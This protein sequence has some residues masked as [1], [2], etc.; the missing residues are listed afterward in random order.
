MT[1][2]CSCCCGACCNGTSC[3]LTTA[4]DCVGTGSV[5]FKGVGTTCSPNPCGPGA[6]CYG[7]NNC[8]CIDGTA[9]YC[10]SIGGTFKGAGTSCET[11]CRS[12]SCPSVVYPVYVYRTGGLPVPG[13]CTPTLAGI[14]PAPG[15]AVTVSGGVPTGGSTYSSVEAQALDACG[16]CVYSQNTFRNDGQAA[17]L[18]VNFFF[19]GAPF[20]G[21]Y[22]WCNNNMCANPLP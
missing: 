4:D 10:Q 9:A 22:P 3:T 6:C 2:T 16:R 18:F 5:S 17:V 8:F 15:G 12:C 19:V 14:V 13:N 11:E 7:N 21:G 20:R 1:C